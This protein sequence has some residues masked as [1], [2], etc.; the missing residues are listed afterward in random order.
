MSVIAA[1]VIGSTVVGAASSKRASDKQVDA[2]NKGIQQTS[3]MA[4]QS[5][6]D[7]IQ[8]YNQARQSGQRGLTSAFNFYQQAA[9]SKYSPI[10]QSGLSAQRVIGQGA[11][12]ANNAI[13][14]LPVDMSFTNPQEIKPDLSFIQNAQLPEMTGEY[15]PAG[16]PAQMGPAVHGIAS[17][18][19]RNA[20]GARWGGI[21]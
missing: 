2:T 9:P 3:A 20:L 17:E 13:L 4:E 10:T 1:A 15:L 18:A 21:R 7:A 6:R 14:G 12:Q 16:E 11:Q 5:R 8:L 19:A